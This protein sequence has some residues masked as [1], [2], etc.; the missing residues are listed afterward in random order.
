MDFSSTVALLLACPPYICAGVATVLLGWSS[1]HF[2]ERTFHI[3]VGLT[4]AVIGFTIA[5]STLNTAG[6]YV[7]CFIFPIGAYSVNSAIVGWV[8][9]TLSQSQEKK[10]VGPSA[11]FLG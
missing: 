1:G 3:T 2:H 9:T 8:A 4:V 7:A 11:I 10:A 5:A 6:R